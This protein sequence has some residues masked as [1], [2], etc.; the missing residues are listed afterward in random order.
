MGLVAVHG[1]VVRIRDIE[2]TWKDSS[3]AITNKS[4]QQRGGIRIF[5]WC[6]RRDL[7][8]HGLRHTPLKR[9]C[10]PFH[11][12]GTRQDLKNPTTAFSR[13][14]N[15]QRAQQFA[16]GFRSLRPCCRDFR[17]SCNSG[18][19]LDC[20]IVSCLRF[21]LHERRVT[22]RGSRIIEVGQNPCQ[23]IEAPV[24]SG[25][26]CSPGPPT[27]CKITT[28]S[29]LR[30][31]MSLN[32]GHRGPSLRCS[33]S[34]TRFCRERPARYDSFAFCGGEDWWDGAS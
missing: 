18:C 6:R 11:H 2:W 28:A 34:I 21:T 17:S 13:H 7:N 23:S 12:F 33:T 1:R 8:P 27:L 5:I 31:I 4:V 20:H 10:L 24:E 14:S 22:V 32:H 19:Q 9:A 26:S 15:P 3:L 25:G 29:P 16:S 30:L